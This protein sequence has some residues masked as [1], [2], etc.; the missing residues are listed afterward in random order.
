[1]AGF[2]M[3]KFFLAAGLASVAACGFVHLA[4][5]RSLGKAA[6]CHF[7]RAF[8]TNLGDGLIQVHRKRFPRSPLRKL[9]LFSLFLLT[10][11][12]IG[13]FLTG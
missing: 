10:A 6:D 11:C 1:M 9:F 3:S 4:M 13:F 7:E 2:S 8:Y 5:I 12:V